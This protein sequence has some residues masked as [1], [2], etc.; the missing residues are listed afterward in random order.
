MNVYVQSAPDTKAFSQERE[1]LRNSFLW[2]RHQSGR[3]IYKNF[4]FSHVLN[5]S[6]SD[7][8]VSKTYRGIISEVLAI[9]L[10]Y[11]T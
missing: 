10:S 5:N 4:A 11:Q 6:K 2:T 7:Q 9:E 8:V 1:A 3:Q